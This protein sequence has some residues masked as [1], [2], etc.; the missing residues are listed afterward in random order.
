MTPWARNWS[1]IDFKAAKMSTACYASTRGRIGS[2]SSKGSEIVHISSATMMHATVNGTTVTHYTPW[3]RK[4]QA[5]AQGFC[6]MPKLN[7]MSMQR[8]SSFLC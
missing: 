6:H 1:K 8:W 5:V 4:C 3:K 2:M 7:T